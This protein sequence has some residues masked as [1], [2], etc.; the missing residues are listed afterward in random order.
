MRARI[1]QLRR[2]LREHNRRYY[3]EDA[4]I[5]GDAEYDALLREL[6]QLERE[7]GEA[8]P[9][10][11]PTRTVG[12]APTATF[13]PRRHEQ[14]LLSLN[15]A[16]SEGEMRDFDRRI[17]QL[18]GRAPGGYIAEAKIDGLAINL[19]YE[20]GVLASA[21]TRGDGTVG[22]DVTANVRTIAGIP[23]RL[24]DGSLPPLLEV[25]GEIY[26]SRAA[27]AHLNESQQEAGQKLFANPRNAAAGSL[28]Q[29]DPSVTASRHLSFFAYGVGAGGNPLADSQSALLHRLQALGFPV[30]PFTLPADIEAVLA[31]Q[32][33]RQQER[34]QMAYEI[35]GT[36]YKVDRFAEQELLGFVARAPRWAIA[37][38]FPA[39]EAQTR[40][41]RIL[42]QVGRSGAITPVAEMEP[43]RVGGVTISRATLHNVEELARKD[44]RVGDTVVVRRAGDVIPEVVRVLFALGERSAPT[45]LP[46]A[47][48]VCGAHS[49]RSEGEVALRCSGGLSCPAQVRERLKHFASRGGMD[50][51]GMGDKLIELLAD[52]PDGSPL[53]LATIADIYRLDFTRLAGR[54][55]F[56]DKKIANLAAAVAASRQPSLPRFLFAL[57][58]RHVGE[59]TAI[60]LANH[61][62]TLEALADADI[63]TLQEVDD[64]GPEV[65]ASIREFFDEEHN[66]QVLAELAASGVVPRPVQPA[67]IDTTHPLTGKTVVVTGALTAMG[68][69]EAEAKLR[70]VG[71]KPTGSVSA[72]TD[73]LVAGE[74]AGS[75]L[76]KAQ[77]LGVPIIGEAEFLVLLG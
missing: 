15:N 27:F 55:G 3:L 43:V 74:A 37:W 8:V 71:A 64:V 73:L 70:A 26:M 51:E 49:V 22:E 21:A 35:D 66:R 24:N 6:E 20:Q 23:Y 56:G 30:Q 40:I 46:A 75:K 12:A 2:E 48:P 42:W 31:E 53:H 19:R 45:P 62:P 57:G 34:P 11:S 72:K 63:P 44:V 16:F 52:E 60:A 32:Q 9:E 18:L 29:L 61:F 4:P 33:L 65:A 10:D 28:R 14:P 1:E 54:E 68:R 17:A 7:L 25:R 59:A 5:I 47:C 41:V 77:Q 76:A 13:A 38:K 69:A 39:E 58:I 36:V 67:A 50:I